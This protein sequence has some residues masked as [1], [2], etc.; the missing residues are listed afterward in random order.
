MER[1]HYPRPSCLHFSIVY[2][3]LAALNLSIL[4]TS[5]QLAGVVGETPP[6]EELFK[7]SLWWLQRTA[8]ALNT[9]VSMIAFQSQILS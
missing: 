4:T 2:V 8:S 5:L 1:G 9:N 3:F 7:Q 6:H